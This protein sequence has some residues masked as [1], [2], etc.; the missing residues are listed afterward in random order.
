MKTEK[1]KAGSFKRI[2]ALAA[3]LCV[4][5]SGLYYSSAAYASGSKDNI[6][7]LKS[8]MDMIKER[9]GGQ[10]SDE[11]LIEGALKGMFGVMDPY[12]TYFTLDEANEFLTDL[13]GT[14]EGI[15]AALEKKGEYIVVIKVF[16]SSPAERAGILS[17]DK[18][19]TVGGVSVVDASVE[20]AV[21][22]I[23]GPAGTKVVLGIVRS[24]LD[25]ML[26]IE[27]E[28][29]E[30]KINPVSYEIRGDI[31]YIKLESFN[32]HA[33]D[34]MT[35]ALKEINAKKIKK[36]ILDLRDNPGGDVAEAVKVARKFVPKGLITKLDFKS[37][38]K[39][40]IEY[41]S[42]LAR[43]KY[44]LAVLV[45]G[46]TASAAEIVAGAVQD[47]GAGTLIGSRT[48]GKALVQSLVPLLTAGAYKKYEDMLGVKVV[49]AHDL[50]EKHGI[51]PSNDEIMGWTKMTTGIYT[52][53]HGRMIDGKGLE[54]DIRVE[55]PVPVNGIDV[56]GIS[57]LTAT[58]KPDL[59]SEGPDVLN[60][61]KILKMLGYD[62]DTPDFK[63][64][65]KT[66]DAIWK[67]RVDSGLWAGGVLDFTTQKKLNEALDGLIMKIDKQYAKAVEVLNR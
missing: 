20:E 39:A 53:P 25:A 47:T 8:V 45:N 42:Y 7:Y 22:M 57:K 40:D 18:I 66:Y 35:K 23:R 24:G 31:G 48:F 62:V 3:I 17:G 19:A 32:S 33:G 29:A 11:Q 58:W 50:I 41:W 27:V 60:A 46:A 14:Y 1:M 43:T 51:M 55:D 37:E 38:A 59:G 67:F 10:I 30:I 4:I 12:T 64:D 13:G 63:L 15:G 9:Y 52:T 5:F 21:R 36:I 6:E 54:P 56:R 49:D 2:I 28:R 44:K 65:R 34:Y 61:E 26:S 16:P